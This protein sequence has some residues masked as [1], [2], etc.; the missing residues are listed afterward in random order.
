MRDK[1]SPRLFFLLGMWDSWRPLS[2]LLACSLPALSDRRVS[3]VPFSSFCLSLVW[4][5]GGA[6]SAV[7]LYGAVWL[8][9]RRSF[10]RVGGRAACHAFLVSWLSA[11]GGSA[12]CLPCVD[13]PG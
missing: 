7:L 13:R 10:P 4:A 12:D 2:R 11:G 9:A 1:T 6:G 8:A 3:C 5:C